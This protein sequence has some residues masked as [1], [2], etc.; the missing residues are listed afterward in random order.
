MS[1]VLSIIVL[2]F[3][4]AGTPAWGQFTAGNL[5][6]LQIGDSSA[7]LTGASTAIFL[8]EYTPAGSLVQTIAIPATGASPR[9]TVIG[10]STSEGHLTRSSD[11]NYLTIVGYDTVTGIATASVQVAGVKRIIGR[12][13][14]AG[15]V[16]L[17]TAFSDG[18]ASAV[19]SAVSTDGIATWT[20]TSTIGARYKPFGSVD[21][22]TQLSTTPTNLRVV[23]VFNGQLYVSSASGAFLA[24]STIGTGTPT[25]SGQ[26]TT[27]LPGMPTT[28]TH[29][30]YAFSIS[31]DGNTLYVA[32]D[33]SVANDGGIQKWTLSAGTWTKAYTLLN[34]GTT[35]TPIRGLT[36]DWSGVNPVIYATTG[37]ATS[38]PNLLIKVTDTGSGSTATTLATSPTN[39]AFRGIDFAPAA[40]GGPLTGTKT[41]PGDYPSL[42]AAITA[43]DTQGVGAGGVTFNV[44]AGYTETLTAPLS[45]TATGTASNPI[46]FQ[47]SGSGANPLI[48]A[49]T[50]GTGTPSTAIQDGIWQLVG[51]D[52]VTIDG[53]DLTDNP[54]N[55]TNPATMEY[56]YALYK[57]SATNGCQ[58]VTIKNCT[59]TLNRVNNAAG[60]GPAVDG[61]RGIDVVNATPT[62]ATTALTITDAAGA[63][64]NNKFYSNTI[65]NCNIGIALIGFADVT[66]FTFA[67]QNNDVGG[68]AISTGNTIKN[69]GGGGTTSPAAGVRTLA[70][71]GINV[72]YNTIN[73]ND[74]GGV[75]HAAIVRGIYLNTAT[76]ANA[77]VSF[78][79]I[80]TKGGGTTQQVSPI[81]NVS[82]STAAGNTINITNNTVSVEYLTA[83]TGVCYG[84]FNSSTAA[85]VNIQNN[86]VAGMSYS[87]VTLTGTG[88]VYGIYN[89]ATAT[90]VNIRGNTVRGISRT[91]TTGGTTIGI[92]AA[93][94]TNETVKLNTVDSLSID[95]TGTTSTMYGIQTSTGTIVVDSN[96]VR[97]LSCLKT[98]GTSAL[99]GIYNI[100]SPTNENYNYNQVYNI[101]HAG[102]GITYG[103]YTFTTTGTRTVSNNVV[104]AIS[105]TG[106]TVAGINQSSSSPSIFKNKIYNIQST[107]T[108]APTVQGIGLTSVGT[109]GAANIY[110]NLIGDLKAPN[111]ST[112]AA[113]APSVR[114]IN[115]TSTTATSTISLSYNTVYLNASSTGTN[116]GT[117]ALFVTGSATA[118]TAAFTLRNNILVNLSTPAGT[119]LAVAYQRSS[120]ALDNYVSASDNNLFYAGTIGAA[121]LIFYDGTN[122][123]QTLAA[124]KTRVAPR[125]ASSITENPPFLST[126]GSN[127]NFLHINTTIPTGIESGAVP[128]AG[129]TDDFD[130]DIRNTTSPDM[131]ADEFNGISADLTPPI[132][133]YTPLGVTSP[134]TVQNLTATITDPSGVPTAGIGR[135]VA[136][137]KINSG[138]TYTGATGTYVSG[139]NFTFSFGAGT[140]AGDTVYYYVAA[141]DSANNVGVSPSAGAG[142]FTANPPAASIPPT[143]PNSYRV[144]PI[145]AGGTY[146]VGT[147]TGTYATLKAAFDAINNAVV[148]GNVTLSILNEGTTEPS[149]AQ[150][151]EVNYA[152][153]GPFT[154]TV[155]PA[156]SAQPTITGAVTRGGLVKLRGADYVT[157][158]GSNTPG[159]TTRNLTLTNTATSF[160]TTV[161][162]VASLGVGA[163][164]RNVTI[165]NCNLIATGNDSNNT[166]SIYAASADTITASTTGADNHNLVIENN[167][168]Q[169]GRFGVYVRG[170]SPGIL[171]GLI[172]RNNSIGSDIPGNEV[173]YRGLDIGNADSALVTG[174]VIFNMQQPTALT[175]AGIHLDLNVS[176]A[177]VSGN[178]VRRIVNTNTGAVG[179]IGIEIGS[180]TGSTNVTIVNNMISDLTCVGGGTSTASNPYGI[181]IVGGTNH[182]VYYN[183]VSLPGAFSGTGT[184]NV[185]AAFIVTVAT[186]TGLDLRNNIF[187]NTMTG[188]TGVR[189][190][191]IYASAASTTFGTINNN[192]YYV[193]GPNGILGR[194]STTDIPDLAGWRTFTG[195][196][197][198][199]VSG[200]PGFFNE[201][202]N[203][204]IDST[205]VPIVRNA[206]TPIAGITTDIDGQLRS[207]T[208]PDIGADE[209]GESTVPGLSGIYTV[210]TGGQ[211][212]TLDSAFSAL[213]SQGVLGPVTF[214]LID[215]AYSPVGR[216]GK[217]GMVA[218]KAPRTVDMLSSDGQIVTTNPLAERMQEQGNGPLDI[219]GINLTGPITG[220]SATNRITLRPATGVRARIVGTGAAT[221]NFLN[222]SYVTFDGIGTTGTTQMAIENVAPG[223]VAIAL[224]GNSDNNILQNM[225]VRAP[226]A[227]GIAVYMDTAA[228]AAPD[229]NQVLSNVIPSG[230]FGMYIR[231]GN[232]VINGT[233]IM[234]NVLGGA[235]DS[236]GAL[237]I[238]N[239]QVAGSVIANNYIQN[240][241]DAAAAGGNIA[242]IW[243][244]TKQLNLRVYN[245]VVNGVRNRSGATGAV[246]A[247]GIYFFGALGDTTR[248]VFYNNMVYNLD[249]PTSGAGTV[250]GFF[251]AQGIRDT[252][253]YNSVHL[254]GSD[255]STSLISAALYPSTSHFLGAWFNNNAVNARTATGTGRAIALYSGSATATFSSDYNN[256]NVP[257]QTGSH[258]AAITTTNYTTLSAWQTTGRDTHSVSVMPNFRAPHLHIDSTITTP[259]DG[260]GRPIAGMTTDIDGQIRN[261]TTPDIGADEFSFLGPATFRVVPPA[262]SGIPG[263]GAFN[264]AI[265]NAARTYQ[266][267]I[268]DSLLTNLVGK[269]L[270]S[271]TWR[272][273]TS[274]TSNWPATDASFTNYDIYLSGSVAPANRSLTFALNVVGPQT[275]VRAGSLTVPAGSYP[276]GG[277][278]NGFGPEIIFNTQWLYSGGHLLIELRHTGSNSN[279]QSCDGITTTTAGYGTDFSAC[280]T[281]SYTGTS[282]SAGNFSIL[283]IAAEDTT[284]VTVGGDPEI[285]VSFAL[286]QNYPNPFNPATTIRYA[287]PY[288]SVVSLRIYNILGQEVATL[289]DEVR[290][291][292]YHTIVWNGRNQYGTQA[293]TGVYFYRIEARPTDASAPYTSIKKMMLIK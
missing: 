20:A 237:G 184:T 173:S 119:G 210:G 25:T 132:I 56:G 116:F 260:G 147:T 71:Y 15:T 48:T 33:G 43:V 143:N 126:V 64:S 252:V 129:I 250:R 112:S 263:T 194:Q 39:T 177:V 117:T 10:S 218:L 73:N 2:A 97:N 133:G 239:Q 101:T 109:A 135:P 81:E 87:A 53:I 114:G 241:K 65:Q 268:Y 110:N 5:V 266:L 88:S 196:D 34:N 165:K 213:Q 175:I 206:G 231:G 148:S 113:T 233:R 201:F 146:T 141:Q 261:A 30:P 58:N 242:G 136:Y 159:G 139:S 26:T 29:S 230:Y 258:V 89:S 282:G 208:T 121:N 245:N 78:N 255:V 111:A 63:N 270:R 217:S 280:W 229:S 287:L 203:L 76:S 59:I 61:S 178:T 293:A 267:L 18:A 84:I 79:T 4:I 180:A 249:N 207:A 244:A 202:T 168:L 259:L 169:R 35:T 145:L 211:F 281:G 90:N 215:S 238:Y 36:V 124:F 162:W 161:V 167:N 182:K 8:K 254:T 41:V 181:R 100:S 176:N 107:S 91:G 95:G 243:I 57:A 248:S 137:W 227:T 160:S 140:V 224:L 106:T 272:L 138:G 185:S 13:N 234:N 37:T 223:G 195:Q 226:Y 52:Y 128:I 172:I 228:L 275:Q 149:V 220:A 190:Y 55:T 197:V 246:F 269:R 166:S 69:Y 38:S 105:T 186:A 14:A 212:P 49:Y 170:A 24:V 264:G 102:T 17:T 19:R 179:S 94:G 240:V 7:A 45:L 1:F 205:T 144:L 118:T 156:S 199:S 278:P 67:D 163:G 12:I 120:T 92:Y 271:I 155:K 104:Y 82:G 219:V 130:G 32:D 221:F 274:A 51:S 125:E 286:S 279:S 99:Y 225:T 235:T 222:V 46:V 214:T 284:S 22:S 209:F 152:A 154:I 42:A 50:G 262:Y 256:L 164:A 27:A 77:T 251:A 93:A 54:A 62:A 171:N 9:L 289:I 283:R 253:V 40:A 83:T 47:K 157:I 127:P 72:S 23:R 122:S 123:D 151:N 216:P 191:A 189:C 232:Y 70:Q 68:D 134:G 108:G 236:L 273:P 288:E 86:T 98:T 150:L 200:I 85:T 247:A 204:H 103:I 285:P 3:L 265:T 131:G 31:P 115:I 193:A 198:N 277:S 60:S 80:T 276:S 6:A 16:D 257:T 192:D 188:A 187:S 21:V 75:N 183:S 174:N 290:S 142:G 28:G 292:G 44:A 158:D 153:G 96:I 66:P 74:G 291:A 11:G